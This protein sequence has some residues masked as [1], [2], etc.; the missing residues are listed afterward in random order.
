[1]PFSVEPNPSPRSAEDRASILAAPGFGAHFT[2]HMVR[3]DFA[4]GEWGEGQVVPYGPLSLDP[5]TAALH[6]GQEIFEGLKAYRQPD[7]SI[8]TFRPDA[9][10]RRFQ[11]SSRRLAMAELPVELF[12]ES[13]RALTEVDRDW[14]PDNPDQSL[15]FR[16]YMIAT[17]IGLGVNKPSSSYTYLLI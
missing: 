11:R 9:N 13:L 1:M 5:A 7:G 6:Y 8:A 17:E 10:A 16:P 4:D 14:V 15:Y 2:D 3:I 12:V